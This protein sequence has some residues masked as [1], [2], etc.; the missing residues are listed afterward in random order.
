MA[1]LVLGLL[2]A[3]AKGAYDT[4]SNGLTAVAAKI[5]LIDRSLAVGG[6]EAQGSRD[7]LRRVVQG[8]V[9][10][11]WPNE[12]PSPAD[13]PSAQPPFAA[14]LFE[15]MEKANEQVYGERVTIQ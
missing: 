11:R 5:V 2:V 3:S 8:T 1:A 12:Q 7:L 6:S 9:D 15:A 10:Q 13:S 4:Q 14:D